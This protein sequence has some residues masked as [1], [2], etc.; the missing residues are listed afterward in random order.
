MFYVKTTVYI[1]LQVAAAVY[2]FVQRFD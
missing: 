2:F 1:C